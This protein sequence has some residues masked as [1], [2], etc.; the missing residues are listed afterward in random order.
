MVIPGP[1]EDITHLCR[2]FR[3]IRAIALVGSRA[4]EEYASDADD[5]DVATY[6]DRKV[7]PTREERHA[8]W[9][10]HETLRPPGV[11]T[12]GDRDDRFVLGDLKFGLSYTPLTDVEEGLRK[13]LVEGV[14]SMRAAPW[15]PMGESPDGVCGEIKTCRPIWDQHGLIEGWKARVSTYPQRFKLKLLQE[16]VFE[17]R[18]NLQD[19][20]RGAELGDLP[21]F[22]MALSEVCMRVIRLMYAAKELY[23]RGS[24]RALRTLRLGSSVPESWLIAVEHLMAMELSVDS[25]YAIWDEAKQLVSRTAEYA[26]SQGTDEQKAVARGLVYWPDIESLP[27]SLSR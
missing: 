7:E 1:I 18:G 17:A 14:W 11:T 8:L 5:W 2:S 10:S 19:L 16:L 3:S 23:F 21:H 15:Y 12:V 13:V 4:T 22:H 24:K 26:A 20:R 27:L 9:S 25:L 6:T